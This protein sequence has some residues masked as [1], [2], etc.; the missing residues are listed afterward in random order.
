M[1]SSQ[2]YNL[3]TS[4]PSI[5]TLGVALQHINLWGDTLQPIEDEDREWDPIIGVEEKKELSGYWLL[6]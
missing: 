4:S 3:K 2:P 5:I 6:E 1:T